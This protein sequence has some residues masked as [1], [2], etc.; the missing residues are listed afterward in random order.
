MHLIVP[1]LLCKKMNNYGGILNFLPPRETK[2]V[3]KIAE[4]EKSRVKVQCL[5]NEK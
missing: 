4:F 5:T 3:Q 1:C 2:I